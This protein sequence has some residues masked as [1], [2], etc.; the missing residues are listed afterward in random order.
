MRALTAVLVLGTLTACGPIRSMK[1]ITDADVELEAA[2]AAGA[3]KSATYEYIAAEAYLHEARD[4]AGRSQYDA[5]A[6]FAD[7]ARGYAAAAR[8][9]ASGAG[10]KPAEKP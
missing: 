10:A 7:K 2:R 4:I 9:K 3:E 1:A 5:A 6:D 8:K